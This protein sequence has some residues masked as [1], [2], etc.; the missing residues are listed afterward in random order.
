MWYKEGWGW[1]FSLLYQCVILFGGNVHPT[2]HAFFV[3]IGSRHSLSFSIVIY[4][5]NLFIN[6]GLH[7]FSC[8]FSMFIVSFYHFV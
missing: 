2:V 1:L 3:F 5:F 8:Y 7:Y 6:S 4:L